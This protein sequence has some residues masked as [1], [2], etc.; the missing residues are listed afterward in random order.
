MIKSHLDKNDPLNIIKANY[1]TNNKYGYPIIRSDDLE[2]T[3]LYPFDRINTKRPDKKYFDRTVHF[4]LNDYK[5]NCIWNNPMKYLN[6]LSKYN[7]CIMPDF[8]NYDDYPEAL[9]IFQMYKRF[10]ITAFLQDY[11]I[12][13]IPSVRINSSTDLD[14]PEIPELQPISKYSTISISSVRMFNHANKSVLPRFKAEV[15][16]IIEVIEPKKIIWYGK[17]I[18][19]IDFKNAEIQKFKLSSKEFIEVSKWAKVEAEAE[20]K[21]EEEVEAVSLNKQIPNLLI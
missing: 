1:V 5:F 8:S 19:S 14:Q 9:N 15:K 21:G 7:G 18:D 17:I 10:W 12:K 16:K 3:N 13:V 20:E 11:G 6:L 4:Y 2:V